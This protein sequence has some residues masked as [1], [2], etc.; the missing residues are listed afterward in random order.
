[1]Q[2]KEIL[3]KFWKFLN[4]DSWQ[5]WIVSLILI[6]LFIKLILFPG[7]SYLTG[8]SLPLVVVESCS[9]YHESNFD[10]WWDKN[11]ART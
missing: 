4:E 8:S 1:M 5:S 9:M 3:T 2:T 7:L 6:V 11:A 10:S